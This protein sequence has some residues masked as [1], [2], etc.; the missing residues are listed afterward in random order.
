MTNVHVTGG[1][2]RDAVSSTVDSFLANLPEMLGSMKVD[3]RCLVAVIG[4]ED[5]R[6]VQFWVTSD[7]VVFGEVISNI[8]IAHI[9][10]ATLLTTE[11]E[12]LLRAMGWREP[13]PTSKPNWRFAAND[14]AELIE[15]VAKTRTVVLEVL[16]ETRNRRVS[17]RTWS[18]GHPYN[19]PLS[20]HIDRG[21]S[22]CREAGRSSERDLHSV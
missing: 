7:G 2:K 17:I 4:F 22:Y 19:L 5:H 12:E 18:M 3:P 15:L 6:Y 8:N 13:A 1:N 21:C 14:V 10:G 20:E 11:D 16:R 9:D